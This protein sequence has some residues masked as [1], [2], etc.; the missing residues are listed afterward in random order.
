[1]SRSVRADVRAGQATSVA[2]TKILQRAA[3][4]PILKPE[5]SCSLLVAGDLIMSGMAEQKGVTEKDVDA[6]QLAMGVKVEAEHTDDPAKANQIALDHLSEIPDYYTRLKKMEDG[7]KADKP[8][9]DAMQTKSATPL[10]AA[11][12]AKIPV[13]TAEPTQGKET[14][15]TRI[16]TEGDPAVGKPVDIDKDIS[17]EVK[18]KDM[19]PGALAKSTGE[20]ISQVTDDVTMHRSQ[21]SSV[22]QGL[23]DGERDSVTR[24]AAAYA[25]EIVYSLLGL[26]KAAE[27]KV[28]PVIKP[29][30]RTD[31][32][33][34]KAKTPVTSGDVKKTDELRIKSASD[35]KKQGE[36]TVKTDAAGEKSDIPLIAGSGKKSKPSE[37]CN[38]EEAKIQKASEYIESVVR[39]FIRKS[40]E[41]EAKPA[42]LSKLKMKKKKDDPTVSEVK[43]SAAAMSAEELQGMLEELQT[44]R[45]DD[46]KAAL[47]GMATG[48]KYGLGI[49]SGLGAAHGAISAKGLPYLASSTGV[50]ALAG[51]SIGSIIGALHAAGKI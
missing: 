40:S 3:K 36:D 24:K 15:A 26:S 12:P 4:C 34:E 13:T 11:Q 19:K 28:A 39:S 30:V 35:D 18:L 8:K 9:E 21:E 47:R 14:D 7:A 31:A 46:R 29:M 17:A 48:A 5:F 38:V 23:I 10:E 27:D 45:S 49:G 22:P 1:M 51:T 41:Q 43:S 6:V 50:G 37:Q 44:R 16:T 33:G 25:E 20:A 32:T 42:P 2:V